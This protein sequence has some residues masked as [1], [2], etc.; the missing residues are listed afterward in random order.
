MS[1]DAPHYQHFIPQFILK[2]FGHPFSCPKAPT[3]GLKCEKHHH[4][5]GKYPDDQVVN[6]LELL[7][8]SY[9]VK[10]R[11][12]RHLCRLDD[13]YTDQSPQATFPRERE[14]NF[15]KLEG[16]MSAAMRRIIGDHQR[17]VEGQMSQS[18][19]HGKQYYAGSFI[20]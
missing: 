10:E 7:P 8:G 15:S 18:L 14:V 2:N 6:C 4:E 3:K 9:E 16:Q 19:G 11:S 1:S 17:N 20:Y 13:M 5:K 12:V